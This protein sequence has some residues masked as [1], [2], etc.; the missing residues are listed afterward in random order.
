MGLKLQFFRRGRM[1]MRS[2]YRRIKIIAYLL[3]AESAGSVSKGSSIGVRI[4][5]GLLLMI[6]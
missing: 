5:R 2:N 1:A 4:E 3:M 6:R